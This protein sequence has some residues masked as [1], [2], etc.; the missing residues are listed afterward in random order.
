M[1][2]GLCN[3]VS[4]TA[5]KVKPR[6]TSL[7]LYRRR[8]VWT[9]KSRFCDSD[10]YIVLHHKLH[11]ALQLFV[12]NNAEV[13]HATRP[14]KPARFT[15]LQVVQIQ[16]M[17]GRDSGRRRPERGPGLRGVGLPEVAMHSQLP[18]L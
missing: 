3:I 6:Q 8:A 15:S 10:C 17:E 16:V 11:D 4:A 12:I 14:N 2:L 5:R 18:R 13:W 9:T 7:E 1:G